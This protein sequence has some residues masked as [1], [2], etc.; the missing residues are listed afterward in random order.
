MSVGESEKDA[1]NDSCSIFSAFF[2]KFIGKVIVKQLPLSGCDVTAISPPCSLTICLHRASPMPEPLGLVVKKG[3]NILSVTSGNM[4][5]PL[6]VTV[7]FHC[8]SVVSA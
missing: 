8:P 3:T 6:S 5:S 2:Y 1:V 4:P 7:N